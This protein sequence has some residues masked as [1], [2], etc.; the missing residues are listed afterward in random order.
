MHLWYFL[1]YCIRVGDMKSAAAALPK[2]WEKLAD[3]LID[4]DDT[5]MDIDRHNYDYARNFCHRKLEDTDPNLE[6][7]KY[8]VLYLLSQSC[9][10][11]IPAEALV[12]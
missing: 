9:D 5:D 6:K 4:P 11:N 12:V 3:L 7:Q 10:D 2:E 1:Y 8:V